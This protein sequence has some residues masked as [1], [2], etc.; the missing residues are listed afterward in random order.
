MRTAYYEGN[1]QKVF[2]MGR[3]MVKEYPNNTDGYYAML[4]LIS[5]TQPK[6]EKDLSDVEWAINTWIKKKFNGYDSPSFYMMR[7][8]L[9]EEKSKFAFRKGNFNQGISQLKRIKTLGD[10]GSLFYSDLF[11]SMAYINKYIEQ[12]TKKNAKIARDAAEAALNN[13]TGLKIFEDQRTVFEGQL[14]FFVGAMENEI[15]NYSRAVKFL[16]QAHRIDPSD[17][18]VNHTLQIARANAKGG[19]KKYLSLRD[20]FKMVRFWEN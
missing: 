4:M 15:G 14:N 10:E 8:S 20:I 11:I 3:Q 12:K 1:F 6:N 2:E 5:K 9:Y 18:N 13:K 7:R 19:K 16:E 17:K